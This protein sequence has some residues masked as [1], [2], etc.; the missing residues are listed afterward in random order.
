MV[1]TGDSYSLRCRFEF[2]FRNFVGYPTVE[3]NNDKNTGAKCG[4]I[5][6]VGMA[7][8]K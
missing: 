8:E 7:Q 2:G 5:G 4:M 1:S 6:P 3:V